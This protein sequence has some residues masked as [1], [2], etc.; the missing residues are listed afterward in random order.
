MTE[1]GSGGFEWE[2][3]VVDWDA[4][5][6]IGEILGALAVVA[7]LGYLGY[8]TRQ[9]VRAARSGARQRI[10]DKMSEAQTNF[11]GAEEN[12]ELISRGLSDP[13]SLT[14]AEYLMFSHWFHVYGNNL[15]NALRLREEG[16]LD[17]EAFQYVSNAFV[18]GCKTAG[19]AYW[20]RES[21]G[22]FP[23]LLRD[24]VSKTLES[25]SDLPDIA[26]LLHVR[27]K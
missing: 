21:Y 27:S 7:T 10:L 3:N 26:K 13:E 2:E 5:G 23:P 17:E 8:Q 12:R 22:V 19:G 20:W 6:A 1:K 15:F 4:I 14:D 25:H 16:V 11:L 18:G 24:Y 9:N